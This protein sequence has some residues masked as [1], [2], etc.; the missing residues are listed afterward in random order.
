MALERLI[1][2]GTFAVSIRIAIPEPIAANFN[3]AST[4]LPVNSIVTDPGE[5]AGAAVNTEINF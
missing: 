3:C 4:I 5:T 1:K 2:S